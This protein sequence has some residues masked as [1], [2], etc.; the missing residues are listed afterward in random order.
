MFNVNN[1]TINPVCL[2]CQLW[3]NLHSISNLWLHMLC[4]FYFWNHG[5]GSTDHF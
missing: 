3:T 1:L 4:F 5:V 2:I